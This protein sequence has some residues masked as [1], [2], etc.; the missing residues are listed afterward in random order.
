MFC[1][2]QRKNP[3][4]ICSNSGKMN[5]I[6]Y[7]YCYFY[8]SIRMILFCSD[9]LSNIFFWKHLIIKMFYVAFSSVIFE[10]PP[11]AFNRSFIWCLKKNWLTMG[12]QKNYTNHND[13]ITAAVLWLWDWWYGISHQSFNGSIIFE[14]IYALDI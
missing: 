2:Y 1:F 11:L 3:F 12:H 5:C 8:Y 9:C 4:V 14:R 10:S 7:I 13:I 6:L